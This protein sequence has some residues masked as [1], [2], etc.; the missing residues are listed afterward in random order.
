MIQDLT[1]LYTG[2]HPLGKFAVVAL[3]ILLLLAII[4]RLVK[5]GILVAFLLILIF[6]VRY[7]IRE[8]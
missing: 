7:V 2:L 3:G 6:V 5:L 1:I 8:L 4:K